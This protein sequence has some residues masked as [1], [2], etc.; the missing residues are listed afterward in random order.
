MLNFTLFLMRIN[1]KLNYFF[2]QE[3]MLMMG[4]KKW[5]LWIAKFVDSFLFLTISVTFMV[6]FLYIPLKENSS[7][8]TVSPFILW[9]VILYGL[10]GVIIFL[11]FISCFFEKGREN[12]FVFYSIYY[13]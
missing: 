8:L 10:G 2:T 13:C 1:D 9:S 7:T 6:L 4:V 12:V 3:L 11:F 5:E